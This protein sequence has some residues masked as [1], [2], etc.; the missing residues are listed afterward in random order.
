MSR[1]KS[2]KMFPNSLECHFSQ[3]NETPNKTE[4]V[5][6]YYE[7]SDGGKDEE[8][9]QLLKRVLIRSE[10]VLLDAGELPEVFIQKMTKRMDDVNIQLGSKY[11]KDKYICNR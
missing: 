2:N 7:V 1:K 11:T 9:N 6:R 10:K 5:A 4:V 3:I 8:G